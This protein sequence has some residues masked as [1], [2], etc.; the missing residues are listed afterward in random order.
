MPSET[1]GMTTS[2]KSAEIAS[3]N[4]ILKSAQDTTDP[5]RKRENFAVSLRKSK[6]NEIIQ[7]KR[8][9]TYKALGIELKETKQ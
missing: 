1:L 7:E 6:K 9:K 2:N 8:R 3:K 4:K 5:M